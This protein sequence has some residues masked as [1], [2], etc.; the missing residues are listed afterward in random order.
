MAVFYG[1]FW[2][3]GSVN[4]LAASFPLILFSSSYRPQWVLGPLWGFG[5]V[6][7]CIVARSKSMWRVQ[8]DGVTRCVRFCQK[9]WTESK[10]LTRQNVPRGVSLCLKPIGMIALK[11]KAKKLR[12]PSL[13]PTWCIGVSI[14]F[15]FCVGRF[16]A[17]DWFCAKSRT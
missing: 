17:V 6:E 12:V 16:I 10:F 3:D 8:L 4:W 13:N 14:L 1:C 5:R 7:L 11:P 15:V 9:F 2:C